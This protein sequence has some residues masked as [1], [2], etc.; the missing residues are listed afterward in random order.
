MSVKKIRTT[1]Y[2][3]QGNAQCKR[4]NRT[5][6]GMLGTLPQRLKCEWRD[7][8]FCNDPCV[9]PCVDTYIC[10]PLT[11]GSY[12]SKSGWWKN[13]SISMDGQQNSSLIRDPNFESN[14]FKSLLK[15]MSVKKIRTTLYQ[16]QG[17]AQ[18]KRF[19]RTL[20]ECWEPC[21]ND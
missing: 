12:Y 2:Q 7:W 17:N 10:H 19:N 20:L 14:L 15:E 6:L 8:G 5:L 9:D 21:H 18:C 11:N 13:S 4:F 16:P 1:L 3:P